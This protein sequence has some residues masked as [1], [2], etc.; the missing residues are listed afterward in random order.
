MCKEV[1]NKDK[2]Y[3]NKSRSNGCSVYCINCTKKKHNYKIKKKQQ[4]EWEKNKIEGEIWKTI[5]SFKKYEASNIGRIKNKETNRITK[6]C[7]NQRGYVVGHKAGKN[8]KFHRLVA[9]A[10]IPNPD[11]KP[12]VNHID[13]NKSNNKVENLEW[14]THSE[15]TQHAVDT[16]LIKNF[17]NPYTNKLYDLKDEE[18]EI[19]KEKKIFNVSGY[20][21]SNKGR[22]K[23]KHKIGNFGKVWKQYITKG[24][25]S[26]FGYMIFCY[27]GKKVAVHRLV[28][29]A[30]IPNP[31][32]KPLVNHIDGNKSNNKV[33]NLEWCTHSENIQHAVDTGLLNNRRKVL[34]LDLNGNIINKFDSVKEAD[35]TVAPHR[36]N[37]GPVQN[38]LSG[39][40]KLYK[41]F[42]FCYQEDYNEYKNKKMELYS[43]NKKKIKQIN[44]KTGEIKIW[45]GICDAAKHLSEIRG[46]K[47][48]TIEVNIGKCVRKIKPHAYNCNWEY[49]DE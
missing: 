18:G 37:S 29:G 15:N 5:P 25:L 47:K 24:T 33:E 38:I 36:N 35:A 32:N 8:F 45:N 40:R 11:N 14:C 20:M 16:G 19:W 12:L 39:N 7:I 9:E 2:F 43:N 41:G 27:K 1:L 46:S 21:I 31:D 30:F 10:F 22:I 42:T 34:Q 3:K 17:G 13:G 6:G 26:G 49:Y 44:I 48:N 28:A 23:G 4:Q